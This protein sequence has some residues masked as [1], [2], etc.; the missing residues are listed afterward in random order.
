MW[1]NCR[2]PKKRKDLTTP[3]NIKCNSILFASKNVGNIYWTSQPTTLITTIA[4]FCPTAP[5]PPLSLPAHAWCWL[6]VDLSHL[7]RG[8]QAAAGPVQQNSINSPIHIWPTALTRFIVVSMCQ[9]ADR[10]WQHV[11]P[12]SFFVQRCFQQFCLLQ[13]RN[14]AGIGAPWTKSAR[15]CTLSSL[16]WTERL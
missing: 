7:W 11:L 13:L 6:E 3:S 14:F 9:C 12:S 8:N 10:V 2:L 1:W 5:P 4:S 15:V 16:L